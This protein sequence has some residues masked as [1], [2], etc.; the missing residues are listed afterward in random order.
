MF[1]LLS[2]DK[3][4]ELKLLSGNNNDYGNRIKGEQSW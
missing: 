3:E 1:I 4:K 2:L